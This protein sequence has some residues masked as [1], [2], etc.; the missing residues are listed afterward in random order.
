MVKS[1]KSCLAVYQQGGRSEQVRAEFEHNLSRFAEAS[2]VNDTR[3]YQLYLSNF[4]DGESSAS[5][6]KRFE[7]TAYRN[8]VRSTPGDG[9]HYLLYPK[10]F[11]N[12]AKSDEVREKL[13]RSNSGIVKFRS[14]PVLV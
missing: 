12:D 7:V 8:A 14:Q 9:Q 1:Y 6:L 2:P 4:P 3:S 11:K 13:S 5:F 10:R